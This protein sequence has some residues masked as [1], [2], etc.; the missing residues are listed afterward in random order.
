[1]IE[2]TLLLPVEIFQPLLPGMEAAPN[3]TISR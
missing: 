2:R 3:G 1:M